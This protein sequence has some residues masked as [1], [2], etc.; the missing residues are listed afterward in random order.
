MTAALLGPRANENRLILASAS[1]ARGAMLRQAGLRIEQSPAAVDEG[2]VKGSLQARGADPEAVAM[3]LAETKALHVSRRDPDAIVI[4]ADQMLV[5][6]NSWFDKPADRDAA[7]RQLRELRGRG[8]RLITAACVL[9]GAER[10]W[11]CTEQATL[12]MRPFSDDFIERYLDAIGEAATQSVGGYQLEAHGA[13]LISAI[14]GDYFVILGLP[15]LPLL[16]FLR[17]QGLIPA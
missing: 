13:Q 8:H 14:E 16:N 1:A 7:R 6:G 12:S 4:G 5:C 10:L 3:A 11:G 15:L 17:G 9:R 2:E